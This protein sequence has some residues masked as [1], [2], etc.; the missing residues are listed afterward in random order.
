MPLNIH[1]YFAPDLFGNI[2]SCVNLPLLLLVSLVRITF[3][4]LIQLYRK[5]QMEQL[6]RNS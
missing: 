5:A 4:A 3:L 2:F 6:S 1:M